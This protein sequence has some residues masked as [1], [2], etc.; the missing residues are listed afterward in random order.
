M[1]PPTAR[2]LE[3]LRFL[4]RFKEQHDFMPSLREMGDAISVE[5]TNGVTDRLNRLERRGLIVRLRFKTRAITI[6]EAGHALLAGPGEE[7]AE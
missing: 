1:N 6:T 4:H 5:S 3:L 2:Q 7:A